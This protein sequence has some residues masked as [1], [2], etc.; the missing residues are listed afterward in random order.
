MHDTRGIDGSY[1]V[2]EDDARSIDDIDGGSQ[3]PT[4]DR[5]SAGGSSSTVVVCIGTA[6]HLVL[7]LVLTLPGHPSPLAQAQLPHRRHHNHNN[8]KHGLQPHTASRDPLLH[9]HYGAQ[10]LRS[11]CY[12]TP[13]RQDGY[14]DRL[15]VWPRTRHCNRI[16]T[17]G[18]PGVLRRSVSHASQCHQP[19]NG[20][21]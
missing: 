6:C 10:R 9:T 11:S 21:G 7:T 20:K 5:N 14:R 17:R 16:C 2:W 1:R 15:L 8:N 4:A 18:R 19:F 3:Q 13:V 12:W